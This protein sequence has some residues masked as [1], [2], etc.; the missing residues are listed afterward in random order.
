MQGHKHYRLGQQRLESTKNAARHR[1]PASLGSYIARSFCSSDFPPIL[2]RKDAPGSFEEKMQ[3][4]N[5]LI[6]EL[7]LD[8]DK[9]SDE[10]FIKS[11]LA[12]E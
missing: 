6:A 4:R 10:A 7:P 12:P 9:I 5:D 2:A 1:Q 8:P 11:D 3:S